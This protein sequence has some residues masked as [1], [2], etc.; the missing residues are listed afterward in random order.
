MAGSRH[1]GWGE[2][3]CPPLDPIRWSW[4][5]TE[6]PVPP[7]RM[8]LGV[9]SSVHQQRLWEKVWMVGG[10]S[11]VTPAEG[12]HQDWLGRDLQ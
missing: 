5:V 11:V 1:S 4:W 3:P 10:E 9:G 2:A 12:S 8:C 7:A 6:S